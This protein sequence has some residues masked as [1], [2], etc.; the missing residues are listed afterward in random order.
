MQTDAQDEAD[1]ERQIRSEQHHL[2]GR[3]Q[4]LIQSIL[5]PRGFTPHLTIS[6]EGEDLVSEVLKK[7][8]LVLSLSDRHLETDKRWL[9]LCE[10]WFSIH[11]AVLV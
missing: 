5:G 4:Q 11:T 10:R 1:S 3:R 9:W 8:M 7:L 6:A 2:E